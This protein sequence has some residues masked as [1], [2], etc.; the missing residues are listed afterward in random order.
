MNIFI[1][2]Y[3]VRGGRLDKFVQFFFFARYDFVIRLYLDC[4]YCM[5]SKFEVTLR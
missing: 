5:N 2:M 3:I 4:S 1:K